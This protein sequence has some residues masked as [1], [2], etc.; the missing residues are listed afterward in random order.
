MIKY[1]LENL[2]DEDFNDWVRRYTANQAFCWLKFS[3]AYDY[4]SVNDWGVDP[5]LEGDNYSFL[6]PNSKKY[7]HFYNDPDCN[8]I[9]RMGRG[10]TQPDAITFGDVNAWDHNSLLIT[11]RFSV[12]PWVSHD[13]MVIQMFG[14]TDQCV[15]VRVDDEAMGRGLVDGTFR[16]EYKNATGIATVTGEDFGRTDNTTGEVTTG[17]GLAGGLLEANVCIDR[18]PHYLAV[19]QNDPA[20]DMVF[21][22]ACPDKCSYFNDWKSTDASAP[23]DMYGN[24]TVPCGKHN[25]NTFNGMNSN[26]DLSTTVDFEPQRVNALVFEAGCDADSFILLDGQIL[27]VQGNL[28]GP[29]EVDITEDLDAY[30]EDE[31]IVIEFY[32]D[33]ENPWTPYQITKA[34]I[35]DSITDPGEHSSRYKLFVY[36][37]NNLGYVCYKGCEDSGTA[38]ACFDGTGIQM[39]PFPEESDLAATELVGERLAWGVEDDTD[40]MSGLPSHDHLISGSG[41][42]TV[43]GTAL[44]FEILEDFAG[45]DT[46]TADS[47]DDLIISRGG[48]E[49]ITG[50]GDGMLTV[51]TVRVYPTHEKDHF[52]GA[53][54]PSD[55]LQCTKMIDAHEWTNFELVLDDPWYAN[56]EYTND[57]DYCALLVPGWELQWYWANDADSLWALDA[58]AKIDIW[59]SRTGQADFCLSS[60]ATE[61]EGPYEFSMAAYC[62][63]YWVKCDKPAASASGYDY[64]ASYSVEDDLVSQAW[65]GWFGW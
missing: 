12:T 46:I 48:G 18:T 64:G 32:L 25:V 38:L 8:Q 42:D 60:S 34:D 7:E 43:T 20:E 4:D 16:I 59:F 62:L 13:Q 40:V 58:P 15:A 31:S 29:L 56:A 39:E 5:F 55:V 53:K 61:C 51:Q 19:C 23:I 9:F 17:T 45:K 47:Y 22:S 52:F 50:A 57:D 1:T 14:V 11:N 21:D 10:R 2:T 33:P 26:Q 44:M 6:M 35:R 27:N 63:S 65:S 28:S 30:P 37:E 3:E 54:D 24:Y 36:A 49:I 41:D